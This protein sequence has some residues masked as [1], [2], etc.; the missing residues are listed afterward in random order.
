MIDRWE[1]YFRLIVLLFAVGCYCSNSHA[2]D[3]LLDGLG[4]DDDTEQAADEE[5]AAPPTQDD[6]LDLGFGPS[7]PQLS[8]EEEQEV[9]SNIARLTQE[10][11]AAKDQGNLDQALLK[12]D[13]VLPELAKVQEPTVSFNVLFDRGKILREQGYVQEAI[14]AFTAATEFVANVEDKDAVRQNYIEMGQLYLETEQY[15]TAISI[16]QGALTL[17]GESRSAELLFN[18]G[19]AQSE[20][21][22]NQQYAR[23]EETQEGL[24]RAILS[25]DRAIAVD[26]NYAEAYYERGTTSLILGERDKAMDDLKESLELDPNNEEAVAQFGFAS[27]NRALSEGSKHNGQRAKIIDDLNIA[28]AQLSRYL[29]LVPEPDPDAEVEEEEETEIKRENVLLQRSAAYI[30]LGSESL[31]GGSDYYKKAIEDAEAVVE[32]I[33]EAPDG[34]YQKGLAYRMLGDFP[35]ALEAF[36]ETLRISPGNTQARFRRG[37]IHFRQGDYQLAL[38]DLKKAQQFSVGGINPPAAFWEGLCHSRMGQ[39]R[40]AVNAYS[41]ALRYQSL[42]TS[43]YL[44]RGIA[45]MKLGRYQRAEAD[46]NEVLGQDRNNSLARSLRDQIQPLISKR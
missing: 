20:F 17:P 11:A 29:Q 3:A 21:A 12:Y 1:K 24:E 33:P 25:Y 6:F 42:Y 22:L 19:Y 9:K 5:E 16:F 44:N 40:Y 32:L 23:A 26:P 7:R 46:F 38:A 30:E 28:V 34:F 43:A 37:I 45:Y 8:P 18:L 2:Q 4:G 15:N 35:S 10:A 14:R 36:D 27:L 41:A 39:H 13:E 31:T